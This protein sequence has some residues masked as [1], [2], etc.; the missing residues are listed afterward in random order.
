MWQG[1]CE[2]LRECGRDGNL[3]FV[4]FQVLLLSAVFWNHG[5]ALLLLC[6]VVSLALSIA[7]AVG[8]QRDRFERLGPLPPLSQRD[9]QAA[10]AKLV[11]GQR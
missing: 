1:F 8:R 3:F 10:R 11:R 9:L 2:K 4:I 7:W 6:V 5:G